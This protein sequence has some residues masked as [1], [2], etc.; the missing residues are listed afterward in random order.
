MTRSS[1]PL[2]TIADIPTKASARQGFE[3]R[4]RRSDK[5]L[6][7]GKMKCSVW[8]DE[9]VHARLREFAFLNNTSIQQVFLEGLDL[10]FSKYGEPSIAELKQKAG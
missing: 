6:E 8:L 1:R 4:Q 3:K 10:V 9:I 2:G 7:E 5:S